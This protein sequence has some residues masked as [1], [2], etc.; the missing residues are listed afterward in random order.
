M[1]AG[2]DQGQARAILASLD[3]RRFEALK[4]SLMQRVLFTVEAEVKKVT[5]VR[6]GNLRRSIASELISVDRGSVGTNV[7]YAPIVHRR[8]PYMEIGLDNAE[9]KIEQLLDELAV[10]FM[11]G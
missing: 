8:N 9:P 4:R 11:S 5:P 3:P 10:E 6:T 7:I 2:F 1:P